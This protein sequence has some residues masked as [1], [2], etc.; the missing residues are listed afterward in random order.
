LHDFN[1]LFN[2]SYF[3]ALSDGEKYFS[4]V[5]IWGHMHLSKWCKLQTHLLEF[6]L[7]N[8]L[9]KHCKILGFV[10]TTLTF[11]AVYTLLTKKSCSIYLGSWCISLVFGSVIPGQFE[12]KGSYKS[13]LCRASGTKK[14]N[15][16][17]AESP[18]TGIS[19]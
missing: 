14:R 19:V 18:E 5:C 10:Y 16:N 1:F 9:S 12:T 15:T 6:G 2:F 17:L 3:I 11:N 4:F 7:S 8:G 13:C